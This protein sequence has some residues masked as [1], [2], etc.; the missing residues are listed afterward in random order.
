TETGMGMRSR[1][2]AMVVD[3]GVVKFLNVEPPGEF[4][5]SDADTIRALLG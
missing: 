2:Y 3:D 4:K 1:R 5:N